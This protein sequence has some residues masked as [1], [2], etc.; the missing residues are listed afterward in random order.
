MCPADCLQSRLGQTPVLYLALRHQVL[1]RAGYVFD[2]HFRIDT[3]L[4]EQ[5]DAVG[6]ESL[7]HAVDHAFD[8]IWPA[9]K[10]GASL[11][12]LLIDVPAELGGDHDPVPERRHALTENALHLMWAVGFGCVEERNAAVVGCSNDVDHLSPRRDRRL[13]RAAHVLHA[14]TDR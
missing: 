5:I 1:D 4:I 7:E 12:G 10:P 13:I 3:M 9:V 6:A 2:R 8:M 14:D 11:A